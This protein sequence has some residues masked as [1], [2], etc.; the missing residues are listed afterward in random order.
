MQNVTHT[1]KV[2][3]HKHS[4]IKDLE[5]A[6][7]EATIRFQE[8]AKARDQKHKANDLRKELCWAYVAEKQEVGFVLSFMMRLGE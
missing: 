6:L 7:K 4:A 8:A 5:D 1:D 3:A 2:L